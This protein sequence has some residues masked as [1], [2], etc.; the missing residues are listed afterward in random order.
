MNGVEFESYDSGRFRKLRLF[1]NKLELILR[2]TWMSRL[3]N[4][5]SFGSPNLS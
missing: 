3:I 5:G 4:A 2:N 1:M